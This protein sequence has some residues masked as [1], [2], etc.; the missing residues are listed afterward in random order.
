M[1]R[2]LWDLSWESRILCALSCCI[3]FFGAIAVY[4]FLWTMELWSNNNSGYQFHQKI[5]NNNYS[6]DNYAPPKIENKK[7]QKRKIRQIRPPKGVNNNHNI[8]MD[9]K[10]DD[11]DDGDSE[12]S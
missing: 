12:E 1:Y 2:A 10:K 3:G 6:N 11:D 7:S 4:S 9:D 5:E 8:E